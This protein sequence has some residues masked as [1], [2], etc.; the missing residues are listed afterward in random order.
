MRHLLAA[1]AVL[2]LAPSASWAIN[3]C[4]GLDGKTVFQ[5]APCAPGRGGQIEVKPASGHAPPP[6]TA[7][8]TATS[9]ASL[10]APQTE[11]ERIRALSRKLNRENRLMTLENRAIPDARAAIDN[12][13][14]QCEREQA[15][16]RQRKMAAANN[17]AGAT[18]EQSISEEMS[19]AARRC[20][21]EIRF[22]MSQLE[23]L[24]KEQSEIKAELGK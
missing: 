12:Q 11:I 6:M 2:C 1:V 8:P 13:R 23:S 5:D 10:P 19:A 21:T 17:L 7:A 14:I 9:A 22:R 4:I 18:W 3:K 24:Q 16:L 15:A 20:D